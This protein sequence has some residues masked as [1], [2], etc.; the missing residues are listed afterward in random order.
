VSRL[1]RA[2]RSGRF[3]RP[4]KGEYEF[5]GVA[6]VTVVCRVE[7]SSLAEARELVKAGE[8]TWECDDVDGDVAD[9]ECTNEEEP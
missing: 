1:L 9:I 6:T 4:S 2:Q 3:H 5:T 7:A 8:C